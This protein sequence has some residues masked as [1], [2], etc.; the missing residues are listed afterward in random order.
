M[1][2]VLYLDSAPPDSHPDSYA[3]TLTSPLSTRSY[4]PP[5]PQS[6]VC[7]LTRAE[8]IDTAV[9]HPPVAQSATPPLFSLLSVHS[10]LLQCETASAKHP[11]ANY[12]KR[13]IG[14]H[15]RRRVR[16]RAGVSHRPPFP[17]ASPHP[18]LVSKVE[19]NLKSQKGNT[20]PTSISGDA[21]IRI[22]FSFSA[23]S[24]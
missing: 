1:L 16:L 24:S 22:T 19:K 7:Q 6:R 8:R 10:S 17:S 9:T 14:H 4:S 18:P 12:T 3:L 11:A 21:Q 15:R 20:P 13:A 2:S 23:S 5:A